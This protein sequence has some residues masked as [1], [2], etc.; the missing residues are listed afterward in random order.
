MFLA[1]SYNNMILTLVKYLTSISHGRFSTIRISIPHIVEWTLV[2]RVSVVISG[3]SV[4]PL[5]V[6]PH[7]PQL[8]ARGLG[9]VHSFVTDV[10]ITSW[11]RGHRIDISYTSDKRFAR[12]CQNEDDTDGGN[13][14]FLKSG[15]SNV[16]YR[17]L[18][19]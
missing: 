1:V 11:L 18:R 7:C 12:T 3:G 4:W 10:A 19:G 13:A 16:R 6:P 9:Y 8:I 2:Y 17:F 14:H 15:W 5:D